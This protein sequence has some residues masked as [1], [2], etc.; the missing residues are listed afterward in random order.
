M[1]ERLPPELV[2]QIQA[3]TNTPWWNGEAYADFVGYPQQIMR[4]ES[5][6]RSAI[7]DIGD[8]IDWLREDKHY[9]Q[10]D[11]LRAIANRM[12]DMLPHDKRR[13]A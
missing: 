8:V 7:D 9:A 10:S 6:T 4:L 12:N 1:T 13:E 11:R 2:Q 5:A 3:H